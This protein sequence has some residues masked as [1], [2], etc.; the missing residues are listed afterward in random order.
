MITETRLRD[1]ARALIFDL[2][3][4]DREAVRDGFAT[5][6]EISRDHRFMTAVPRLTESML[7]HLVD[8]V[9]GVDHVAVALVVLDEQGEGEPAGIARIIR[10][11]NRPTAADV[12][13]TV[14]DRWQGHGVATALLA[15]L[16]RRRPVG[17]TQIATIVAEDNLAALAMVRRLGPA[18]VTGVGTGTLDVVVD[19][20]EER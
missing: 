17:V 11:A 18:T 8:E 16:V 10:Y 12:A 19:L 20:P 7:R 1:G 13:V 14:Y 6:S 15:E 2:E 5:L 9:D 3:H 4:G